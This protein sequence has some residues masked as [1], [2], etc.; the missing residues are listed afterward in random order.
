MFFLRDWVA[1]SRPKW[2]WAEAVA[3]LIVLSKTLLI[4]FSGLFPVSLTASTQ[5][6]AD[7]WASGAESLAQARAM[8]MTGFKVHS[9]STVSDWSIYKFSYFLSCIVFQSMR[10]MADE[11][12]VVGIFKLLN[13][14]YMWGSPEKNVENLVLTKIDTIIQHAL[15]CVMSHSLIRFLDSY[16]PR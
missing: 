6:H 12:R 10:S 5:I 7:Q 14:L 16:T 1:Y 4:S 2:C 15:T 8:P 9:H 13:L 11:N 3:Q